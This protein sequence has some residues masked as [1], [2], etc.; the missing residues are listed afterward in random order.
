MRRR[1]DGDLERGVNQ[2]SP[3]ELCGHSGY[4]RIR[5]SSGDKLN[6]ELSELAG[7]DDTLAGSMTIQVGTGAAQIVN[8]SS[9]TTL[10]GLESGDRRR[11]LRGDGFD[12][13]RSHQAGNRACN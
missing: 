11:R 7:A 6:R 8:L 1:I 12:C 10:A 9:G 4:G 3:A 13:D 2:R 5:H